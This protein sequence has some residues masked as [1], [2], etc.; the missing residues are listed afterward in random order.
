MV[1]KFPSRVLGAALGAALSIAS[2]STHAQE[3]PEKFADIIHADLP[4]FGDETADKW[5]QSF[6][7]AES[8]GFGCTSRVS[9]GDWA[10]LQ[11][12]DDDEVERWYRIWNYGVFHCFAFA[13]K[14]DERES[15]EGADAKPAF[16]VEVGKSGD[17]ELWALQIG[18]VP[19]SYY[20]LLSRESSE[21][22]ISKFTVLQ[23]KCPKRYVRDAGSIDIILTRYCAINSKSDLLNFARRMSKLEPLGELILVDEAEPLE[24]N[25]DRAD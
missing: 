11:H 19:G 22:L 6:S 21:G 25:R 5:P 7:D 20:L 2:V 13:A 10:L 3:E 24:N 16:F 18:A 4:L 8:G 9:F 17:I 1:K 23:T 12:G 15:L 14:A